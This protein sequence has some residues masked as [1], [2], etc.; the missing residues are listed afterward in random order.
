[1]LVVS[2]GLVTRIWVCWWGIAR[3]HEYFDARRRRRVDWSSLLW[4]IHVMIR[5]P[6]IQEKDDRGSGAGG[7]TAVL[8]QRERPLIGVACLKKHYYTEGE[9]TSYGRLLV[10]PESRS[11]LIR[12]TVNRRSVASVQNRKAMRHLWG[13]SLTCDYSLLYCCRRL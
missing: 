7:A 3:G 11:G 9:C 6:A 4:S 10:V 2:D 13:R 12:I 8:E 1:M 5:S